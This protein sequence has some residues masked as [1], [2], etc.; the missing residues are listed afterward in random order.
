[1]QRLLG[2]RLREPITRKII[3]EVDFQ[4]G[5]IRVSAKELGMSEKAFKLTTSLTAGDLVLK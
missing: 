5:V 2:R 4:E 3:N 1:M